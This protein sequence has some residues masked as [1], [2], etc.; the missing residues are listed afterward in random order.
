MSD[1]SDVWVGSEH[2]C[3][4]GGQLVLTIYL[5]S[6]FLGAQ[7]LVASLKACSCL[8]DSEIAL[9]TQIPLTAV[10]VSN[11]DRLY[12]RSIHEVQVNWTRGDFQTRGGPRC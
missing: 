10:V 11:E 12:I 7:V 1:I 6:F 4:F 5:S 9:K 8:T 2:G 3:E